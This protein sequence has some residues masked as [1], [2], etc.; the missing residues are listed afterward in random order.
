MNGVL[1]IKWLKCHISI[2]I[3]RRDLNFYQLM[4]MYKSR[5]MA[6]QPF[7]TKEQNETVRTMNNESLCITKE[8]LQTTWE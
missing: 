6:F 2:P 1:G 3:H 5:D 4:R 8:Y 7:Q